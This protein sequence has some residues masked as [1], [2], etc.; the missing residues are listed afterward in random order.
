MKRLVVVLAAVVAASCGGSSD[1]QSVVAP[2][3]TVVTDT[4]SGTAPV[5]TTA[6]D[7]VLHSFTVQ[8]GGTVNATMTAAGPPT[9]IT[10]GLGIGNP[11]ATGTCALI[12]GGS[13]AATAGTTAQLTGT[14]GAGSYCVVVF[15][16]GNALQPVAYTVAVA[17][18]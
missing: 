7:P 8:V 12:S 11:T 18:T 4:F 9:T 13:V 2:T 6:Q 15:D 3:G 16:I 10:M 14:I 5:G 1:T 17:H